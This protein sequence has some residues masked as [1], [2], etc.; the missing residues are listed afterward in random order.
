MKRF[1]LTRSAERDLDLV[2]AYLIEKA[3]PTVTRSVMKDIRSGLSLLGSEPG[4]GHVR[5]DLT[6]RPLKFWLVH[7]YLIVYE[8]EARPV[9]IL[10][11][12]HGTRDLEDILN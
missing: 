4:A 9:Q 1:V 5:E 2:K 8:P 3:G 12:L 11:I 7:P 10:R 6:D